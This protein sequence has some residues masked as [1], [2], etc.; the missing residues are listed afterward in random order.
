MAVIATSKSML[1]GVLMGDSTSLVEGFNYA[2]AVAKEA[3]DT[4]Y[5]LGQVVVYN[6]TDAV[7]VLKNADF[8]D[9]TTITSTA[10]PL[11]PNGAVLAVVVGFDSLGSD[12]TKVVG[13]T[14]TKVCLAFRGIAGLKENGLVFDAG[15]VAARVATAKRQLEK[16]DLAVKATGEAVTSSFYGV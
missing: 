13:T 10:N 2:F 1:S 16:Q 11:L 6:G 9:D 14:A 4:E 3:A 5:K 8:T 12:S 7:K 15:V